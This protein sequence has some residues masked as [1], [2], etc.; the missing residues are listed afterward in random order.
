MER[1][2]SIVKYK[3]SY[4]TFYLPVAL[5]LAMVKMKNK[6]KKKYFSMKHMYTLILRSKYFIDY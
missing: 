4:Y 1:Y 3:T 6:F 2:S 5:S